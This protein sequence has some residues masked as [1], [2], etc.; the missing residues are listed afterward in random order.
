MAQT[1][2]VPVGSL[3]AEAPINTTEFV[4][5]ALAAAAEAI[6]RPDPVSYSTRGSNVF[7]CIVA[8]QN[9]S[10]VTGGADCVPVF[11][12]AMYC[13]FKV[14]NTWFGPTAPSVSGGI[15]GLLSISPRHV[16]PAPV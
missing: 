15:A 6:H 4:L 13:E 9:V 14:V 1:F 3:V 10:I 5:S 11:D 8:D 12:R 7:E 16:S 2:Q